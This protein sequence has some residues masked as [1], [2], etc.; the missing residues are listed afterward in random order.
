M[1]RSAVL[2][3]GQGSQ[4]VG[5]LADF[6]D[7][8]A[9]AA[10]IS[11]T[12]A[13]ASVALDHDL[14]KLVS[15]GPAERLNQTCWT[16]PAMLS[17]DIAVWRI[18]R[19][20][21]GAMPEAMAGHS[22]GEYAALVAAGALDFGDAVRLVH[23][24]GKL[25][26]Q[27]VVKGEGA[28]AAILGL[29]DEQVEQACLEARQAGSVV[30]ANYN[31]PGQ[32]V[33]AGATAAVTLAVDLCRQAGARR[34]ML[35]PVS[36]PAHSPLMAPAASGL[37]EALG[38][39]EITAPACPVLH[40]FDLEPRRD[41]DAIRHA[42]VEQLTH[43]VRWTATVRALSEKGILTFFECGPGRVLCGLGRRIERSAEWLPLESPQSMT[44][45]AQ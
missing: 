33:I 43:P 21:G 42:L 40:N 26:Q 1:T 10:L 5:M 12:F 3:P 13:V 28:M 22:L 38:D 20:R 36:V 41:A 23:Q 16:Q 14:W 19:A 9:A 25:M 11:E 15:E 32:L 7:D 35:L 30:A 24:R 6:S 29:A 44:R 4:S 17:A 39:T 8:K 45:D 18:F 34:A 2:F 27:A 37:A 31:S